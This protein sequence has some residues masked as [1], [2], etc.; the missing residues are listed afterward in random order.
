M[1]PQP[2]KRSAWPFALAVLLLLAAVPVGYY[3]FLGQRSAPASMVPPPPPAPEVKQGPPELVLGEVQGGVELKRGEGDWV[4]V[5][6]GE[7]LQSSDT[8][9]TGDGAYAVLI[10]GEAYE[11]RMEPGTEIS[12][13]Q[14]TDSISRLLLAGG[15]ASAKVKGGAKHT[16]EVRSREGDATARTAAGAFTISSNGKGT[17]AVGTQEGEV[18][19]EGK[20]KAVIVRAGQQS[21]VLPGQ[22]PSAPTPV[23]S[24]LL[25]KVE[26]PAGR[27][28]NRRTLVLV[29]TAAPGST[30]AVN[31]QTLRP[32]ADG[33]F[34]KEL[35]LS[36]GRNGV[37]VTSKSVGGAQT[38]SERQVDVDTTPPKMGVDPKLWGP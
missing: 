33:R 6:A 19:L 9:R 25:L 38:T 8:V 20:G 4:P 10:G 15:M 24:S 21:I 2:G 18:E 5:S 28:I 1:S 3:L 13:D 7:K 35:K 11:V 14:L 12:V 31:G 30:V 29:G 34:R 16:F 17:V 23:P 37:K 32:E 27:Q 26:W 36:E 22:G